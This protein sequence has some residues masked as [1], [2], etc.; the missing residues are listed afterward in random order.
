MQNDNENE[1]DLAGLAVGGA[2]DGVQ[3]AQEESDG[4][5]PAD[6]D[7]DPVQD[8]QG[9]PADGGHGDPDEVRVAV[10]RPALEEVG[11][12]GAEVAQGAEEDDGDDERVA[13]DETCGAC[14][15]K[16]ENDICLVLSSV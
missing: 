1:K 14:E 13:V 16:G 9:R 12:F 11:G 10:E 4:Q 8:G 15:R 6:A 3:V 2:E 7:E 5:S